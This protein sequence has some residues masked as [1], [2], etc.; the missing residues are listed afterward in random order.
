M[1][2]QSTTGDR[3]WWRRTHPDERGGAVNVGRPE[4]IASDILGAGIVLAAFNRRGWWRAATV[5]GG[6]LLLRGLTGRSAVYRL[7]RVSSADLGH[8]AGVRA[9]AVVTVN[10]PVPRVYDFWRDLTN[11]PKV[12]RHLRAVDPVGHGLSHWVAE[13]PGGRTLEWDAEIIDQRENEVIAWRSTPGGD[14]EHAG[15]VRFREAPGGR[16]TEVHVNL[17]YVP[18]GGTFGFLTARALSSVT[19]Q[20]LAEELRHFKSFLETGEVVTTEGQ[21]SGRET[22][23][24]PVPVTATSLGGD[25]QG[26]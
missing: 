6:L 16:G 22:H 7:L 19:D 18:K 14:L 23:E 9:E 15:S 13:A 1:E 20:R 4:R 3:Y 5:A 21:T 25:R 8:G 11:L 2:M 10:A 12:M 24:R 26:V 17:R